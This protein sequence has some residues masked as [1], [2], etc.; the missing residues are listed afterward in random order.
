MR[1]ADRPGACT[2]CGGAGAT[3]AGGIVGVGFTGCDMRMGL[4]TTSA[5]SVMAH[6][7][8]APPLA[9]SFA[10]LFGVPFHPATDGSLV[11]NL[12]IWA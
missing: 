12:R 8:G 6:G 3:G 7:V 10:V 5:A 9:I 1:P 11:R 2:R 4:P